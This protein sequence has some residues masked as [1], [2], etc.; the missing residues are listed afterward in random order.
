ME[1]SDANTAPYFSDL[2]TENRTISETENYGKRQL[3]V[4]E[5]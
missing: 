4:R 1:Q 5:E 3:R 2:D